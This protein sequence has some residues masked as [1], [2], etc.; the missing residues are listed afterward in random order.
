MEN[1]SSVKLQI[2]GLQNIF[3]KGKD[4]DKEVSNFIY[5]LLSRNKEIEYGEKVTRLIW[6][7]ASLSEEAD[8]EFIGI[9][10]KNIISIPKGMVAWMLSDDKWSVL[11]QENGE[12]KVIANHDI[13]WRWKEECCRNGDNRVVGDF[14]IKCL[15]DVNPEERDYRLIGNA[16]YDFTRP[17]EN[18]DKVELASYDLQW[19]EK[20]EEFAD[21]ILKTVGEDIALRVEHIGSTAIPGMLSKPSIDAAIEIPSF[22]EGRKRVIPLLNNE[23]WEYWWLEDDVVFYKRDKFMGKRSHYLHLAPAGHKLWHRVAFRDYLRNHK[24]DAERYVDLKRKAS[25]SSDGVWMKYTMAKSDFV[26]EITE[27]ALKEL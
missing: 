17:I 6:Y 27:K 16:Y 13:G 23:L 8:M 12:N 14:Y 3:K 2:I 20:Y 21:W 9:E 10:V 1:L 4:G 24:E 26:K 15:E 25:I 7:R 19:P 22:G 18:N 11:T 5:S